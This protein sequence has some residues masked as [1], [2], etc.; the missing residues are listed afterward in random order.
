M[1]KRDDKAFKTKL[2]ARADVLRDSQ[3]EA[4]LV[5]DE[6]GDCKI[7]LTVAA[8]TLFLSS[9]MVAE[10]RR[11]SHVEP[12]NPMLRL[13]FHAVRALVSDD[14]RIAQ[15][16]REWACWWRV[17]MKPIG[18]GIIPVHYSHRKSAIDAEVNAV[19]QFFIGA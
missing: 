9:T 12:A 8:K 5:I 11:A 4:T 7:V 18:G 19:N 2:A 3:N 14:S 1:Y 10:S 17:N 15:W 13:I 6:N 16:T